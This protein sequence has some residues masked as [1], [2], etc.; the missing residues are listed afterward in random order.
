MAELAAGLNLT[1][2]CAAA[3]VSYTTARK[4]VAAGRRDPTGK[5]GTFVAA[6]DGDVPDADGR[7]RKIGEVEREVEALV[8][9][10]VLSGEKALAAAQARTLART[11]DELAVTR[12]GAAAMAVVAA[13]R[14]LDEVI[15]TL[16]LPKRDQLT[17]LKE[18]F[19][20]ERALKKGDGRS[21]AAQNS[22]VR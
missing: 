14:R 3:G 10:R 8:A 22:G 13:S 6:I 5:Y 4:W 15:V 11:V 2:A 1:E 19:A 20:T 16:A 12:G 7:G 21:G 9:G 17:E 18:R